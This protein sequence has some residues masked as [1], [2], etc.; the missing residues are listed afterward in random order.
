MALNIKCKYQDSK[1]PDIVNVD[2]EAVESLLHDDRANDN[3]NLN[4]LI[5]TNA[6]DYLVLDNVPNTPVSVYEFWRVIVFTTIEE[7]FNLVWECLQTLNRLFIIVYIKRHFLPWKDQWAYF[8]IFR[9]CN[10]D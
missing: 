2:D 10:F 7:S 3:F 9:Y 8:Y 5:Y 4:G 1:D 6:R